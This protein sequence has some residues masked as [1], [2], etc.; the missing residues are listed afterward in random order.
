M[1]PRFF[2]AL[3][4]ILTTGPISANADFIYTFSD[5]EQN[6]TFSFSFPVDDFVT[7]AG[8]LPVTPFSA[9]EFTF[10]QAQANLFGNGI[11]FGFATEGVHLVAAPDSCE[12]GG[13]TEGQ[14]ALLAVFL[15]VPASVG[16]HG[17][18]LAFEF[19][20]SIGIRFLTIS[21]TPVVSEPGTLALLC[22]G[23]LVFRLTRR[24]AH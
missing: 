15:S 10:T 13:I 12:R 14:A 3:V 23:L 9:G 16:I 4:A 7:T 2:G 11:C 17:A 19:P 20:D 5:A 22:L 24:R 18:F 1:K 8:T 21:S 6:P